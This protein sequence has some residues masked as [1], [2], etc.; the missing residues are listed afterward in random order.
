[1]RAGEFFI[2]EISSFDADMNSS[3]LEEIVDTRKANLEEALARRPDSS[4]GWLSRETA[5]VRHV[6]VGSGKIQ[7]QVDILRIPVKQRDK[8]FC[9]AFNE[10]SAC[11]RIDIQ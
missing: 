6:Q 10:D 7:V 3:F 5:K 2:A 1:M 8:I 9:N 11:S 4:R